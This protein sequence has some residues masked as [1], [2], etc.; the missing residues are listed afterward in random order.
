MRAFKKKIYQ[1]NLQSIRE[2]S[3]YFDF[4]EEPFVF[5]NIS[6]Q[7]DEEL[8]LYQ[9]HHRETFFLPVNNSS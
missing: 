5:K 6:I 1:D 9:A 7:K 3:F 8:P 4:E 2:Q